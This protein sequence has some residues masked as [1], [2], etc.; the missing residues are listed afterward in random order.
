MLSTGRGTISV[1]LDFGTN[2]ECECAHKTV[3][4]E[5]S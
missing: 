3:R 4:Q 1:A 5:E 2:S